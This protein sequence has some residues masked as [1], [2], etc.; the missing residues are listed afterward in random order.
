MARIEAVKRTEAGPLTRL[1]Y[2]VAKRQPGKV[3]EPIAVQA[4]HPLLTNGYG[5]FELAFQR[6]KKLPEKLKA[7]A[8]LKAAALA[9]CEWCLDFGSWVSRECGITDQQLRDLPRYR[10]S[11]AF[12]EEEKLVI[13]YAE[14]HHPDAHRRAGRAVRATARRPASRRTGQAELV[15]SNR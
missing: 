8:E 4:H 9:G 5:A 14:G 15:G 10:E 2:R 11:D 6:S 13:E 12:T 3:P 1:V 7:L